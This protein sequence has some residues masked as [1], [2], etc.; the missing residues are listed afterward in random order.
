MSSNFLIFSKFKFIK[1]KDTHWT[2]LFL[3][4]SIVWK[5]ISEFHLTYAII[6]ISSPFYFINL[7][8]IT[9]EYLEKTTQELRLRNYSSK[10]LIIS[11]VWASIRR[12]FEPTLDLLEFQ[13]KKN[14]LMTQKK[15]LEE[16]LLD[17][18]RKDNHWLEF[19]RNWILETKSK[20]LLRKKNFPR[21][22]IF[23][24]KSA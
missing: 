14:E 11:V 8:K 24:E 9:Q 4:F 17:F 12:R 3:L 18:E 7:Y 16:K 19:I 23:L 6:W 13:L 5:K 22:K 10:T 15:T 2:R 1:E 20:I 21:W